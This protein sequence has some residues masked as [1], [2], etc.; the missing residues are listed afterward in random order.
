MELAQGG[1]NTR[2]L[3]E[4]T[5]VGLLHSEGEK[6]L[7]KTISWDISKYLH[8]MERTARG[9]LLQY[10][11]VNLVH[12]ILG[13]LFTKI[14]SFSQTTLNFSN[15]YMKC[16]HFFLSISFLFDILVFWNLCQERVYQKRV[17]RGIS[18]EKN[19]KVCKPTVQY[20]NGQ[21]QWLSAYSKTHIWQR[22]M[23][24]KRWSKKALWI[25]PWKNIK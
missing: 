5:D 12:H 4:N 15:V 21:I 14:N 23:W 24:G 16:Y 10:N 18:E 3:L 25:T 19:C 9:E 22:K 2:L 17:N 8:L 6:T 13:T 11:S 1:I 20:I 7:S